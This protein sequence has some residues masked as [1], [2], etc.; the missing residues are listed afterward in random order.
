ME[1]SSYLNPQ[2]C[3]GS[4]VSDVTDVCAND[5]CRHSRRATIQPTVAGY[6]ERCA[7]GRYPSQSALTLSGR[8]NVPVPSLHT[9]Q[10]PLFTTMTETTRLHASENEEYGNTFARRGS[11]TALRL[12]GVRR[13]LRT[14]RMRS[15]ACATRPSPSPAPDQFWRAGSDWPAFCRFN[16]NQ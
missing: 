7:K 13:T 12:S 16:Y 11:S 6:G 2:S 8:G 3:W 15:C 9:Q 14:P 10:S 5:R 1:N 4:A